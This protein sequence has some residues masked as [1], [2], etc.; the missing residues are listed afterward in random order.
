MNI[1][2]QFILAEVC[3]LAFFGTQ[4][5]S[6]SGLFQGNFTGT[7]TGDLDT[8]APLAL[9]MTQDGSMVNGVAIVGDGIKVDTGG[10]ICPGLVAVPAVKLNFKGNVS[11][12]NPRHMEARSGLTVS[13]LTITAD[14]QTELSQDNSTIKLELKLNIPRPCRSTTLN[15]T[16]RRI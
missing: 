5:A 6:G 4:A 3:C 16:L 9:N 14:V 13:G 12:Q 8:S 2:R 1:I 7:A 10:F 11:A 15:A